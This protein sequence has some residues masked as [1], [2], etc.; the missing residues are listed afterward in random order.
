[1]D[2]IIERDDSASDETGANGMFAPKIISAHWEMFSPSAAPS[3]FLING[4]S[5]D[6]VLVGNNAGPPPPNTAIVAIVILVFVVLILLVAPSI[7]MR[8]TPVRR[9]SSSSTTARKKQVSD[10]QKVK[11]R[12]QTISNWLIT[13]EVVEHDLQR[14][15]C[16]PSCA[17]AN[18]TSLKEDHQC[19]HTNGYII[20]NGNRD[21]EESASNTNSTAPVQE[22]DAAEQEY[23]HD[24]S[25][26]QHRND[27]HICMEEFEVGEKVSWSAS[28]SCN[29]AYHF[30]CIKEWLLKKKDCPYCRQTMLPI[31]EAFTDIAQ[32][33][34]AKKQ[35]EELTYF[36]KKDGLVT[37]P[38]PTAQA[39]SDASPVVA[40]EETGA[41][42]AAKGD[43]ESGLFDIE[44]PLGN[45]VIVVIASWE[46]GSTDDD[47][48]DDD[49]ER[50]LGS[51]STR[52]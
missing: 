49:L 50:G 25:D 8:S 42:V 51:S 39:T 15:G 28:E 36:C 40:K 16:Q 13:K 18:A 24:F 1:M 23:D 32:L 46:E 2:N 21:D 19:E 10:P 22:Q 7:Y 4:T 38:R 48:D 35:K 47:D 14:S 44:P 43:E 26:Y 3:V 27:C 31:D 37:M 6:G 34:E 45:D 11:R 20:G 12:Y 52:S 9:R 33:A 5:T 17:D 30:Q 41:V 29:H